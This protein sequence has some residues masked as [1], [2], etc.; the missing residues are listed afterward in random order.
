MGGCLV[1]GV[2]WPRDK[3]GFRRLVADRIRDQEPLTFDALV[4]ALWPVY[5]ALVGHIETPDAVDDEGG[6]GDG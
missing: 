3:D 6:S 5:F 1:N 2:E 4:D